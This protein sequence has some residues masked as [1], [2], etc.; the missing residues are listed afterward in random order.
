MIKFFRKIRQK[1]LTENKF[2]KYLLYAIGEII[3]VVIGILIALQINNWNEQRK[4]NTKEYLIL[5]EFLNSIN[6]DLKAYENGIIP[7]IER[8]KSGLD[9]LQRYVFHKKTIND[10]L[11]LDFY[12]YLS[13][14]TRLRFDNG[15]FEA[16]K[17]TGLDVIRNDSLRKA[18]NN[19]YS[20]RLPNSTY[21]SDRLNER[22][23]SKIS[24]FQYKFLKLKRVYHN[25]G[26]EHMHFD[27]KVED[28]LNNQD[29]LWAFD[30]ERQKY[31]EYEKRLKSIKTTLLELKTMI[32]KEIEK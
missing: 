19:A 15:P 22:N 13:I 31:E 11:F 1:M 9:S 21:F 26:R 3:L 6:K 10:L 12:S 8:K 4:V 24:K 18:I 23:E 30:L 7:R 14:D 27:L 17:S 29:F 20:S 28:I 32:E 16:L 2:N 25:D 5:N